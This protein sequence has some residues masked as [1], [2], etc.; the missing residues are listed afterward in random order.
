MKFFRFLLVGCGAA[1][2]QLLILAV[3]L[4]IFGIRYQYAA[5]FAYFS[6]VLFHYLANRRFT[7]ELCGVGGAKEILS[8]SL[9]VV[10]NLIITMLVTI[11][12]VEVLDLTPY[13]AAAFSIAVTI[14]VT[15]AVSKY[16]IFNDRGSA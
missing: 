16:L 5:A 3:C 15:F 8:Y 14:G 13:L 7:F 9:L 1:G 6:S 11:Y 4:R 10:F 12:V 2:L